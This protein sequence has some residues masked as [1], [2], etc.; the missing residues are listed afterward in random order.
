MQSKS[1]II[2]V[3]FYGLKLNYS[4]YN[5]T[6]MFSEYGSL[7]IILYKNIYVANVKIVIFFIISIQSSRKDISTYL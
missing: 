7:G 5:Q 4:L 3:L 1:P 2:R 6:F